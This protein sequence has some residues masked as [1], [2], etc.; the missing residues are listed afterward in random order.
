MYDVIINRV[1]HVMIP[2]KQL[3]QSMDW[4]VE[5]LGFQVKWKR[6]DNK[7]VILELPTGPHFFLWE[8]E[9]DTFAHFQ[10]KDGITPVIGLEAAD[11]RTLLKKLRNNGVRI[12]EVREE[13]GEGMDFEFF[14]PS[15]N[16]LVVH[17]PF[18]G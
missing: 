15:G 2:V 9:H 5:N 11:I 13:R 17:E 7:M 3:T 16:M 4:Y 6:G 1:S 12:G 8:T 10:L 18:K 14:D